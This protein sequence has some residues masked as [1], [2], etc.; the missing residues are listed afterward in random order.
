VSQQ[1]GAGGE[2]DVV[3]AAAGLV[4]Q[5]GGQVALAHPD[6]YPRFWL[7]F[8]MFLQVVSLLRLT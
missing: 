3:A 1:P 6:G 7:M 2:G 4:A 5:R 8:A